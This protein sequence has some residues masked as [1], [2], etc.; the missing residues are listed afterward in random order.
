MKMILP[1]IKE[2]RLVDRLLSTFFRDYKAVAFKK[3]IAVLCR[4]YHLK[5][6]SSRVVR[7]YR[8][9]QDRR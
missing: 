6:S 3:A 4:F 2:R 9:G 5:K 8:L 7:I 1:P